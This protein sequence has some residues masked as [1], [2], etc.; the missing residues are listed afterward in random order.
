[1]PL[2]FIGDDVQ[3]EIARKVQESF[4]L[5]RQSEKLIETAVRAVEIAIEQDEAAA[6]AWQKSVMDF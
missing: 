2:P 6:V 1:M 5:R 4:S 3:S